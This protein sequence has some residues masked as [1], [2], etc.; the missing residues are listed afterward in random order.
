MGFCAIG[1]DGAGVD[2][3]GPDEGPVDGYFLLDGDGVVFF[4]EGIEFQNLSIRFF[5][6]FFT[7]TR[8]NVNSSC[9]KS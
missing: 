9:R 8:K 1:V 4:H 5:K 2:H 7:C 3:K 6:C